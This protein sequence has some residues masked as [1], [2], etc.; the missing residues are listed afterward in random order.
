MTNEELIKECAEAIKNVAEY[1]KD[2]SGKMAGAVTSNDTP[3]EPKITLEEV[4]AVLAQ[5]S[6]DGHT[7]AIH[8]LLEK[9][10]VKKLSEV[11]HSKYS[12]LLVLA[13]ELK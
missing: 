10:G 4:R 9:F 13:K 1:L 5:K 12:E 8:D 6:H 11:D 2:L 7:A 3:P